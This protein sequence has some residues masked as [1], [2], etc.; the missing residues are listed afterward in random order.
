MDPGEFSRTVRVFLPFHGQLVSNM[1][2]E[3]QSPIVDKQDLKAKAIAAAQ[4]TCSAVVCCQPTESFQR[5]W[6]AARS[7]RWR[8]E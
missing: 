8:W 4:S 1:K 3:I 6:A 7:A 2:K 5:E